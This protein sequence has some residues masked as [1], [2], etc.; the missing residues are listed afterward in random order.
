[1]LVRRYICC[2]KP[3][4]SWLGMPWMTMRKFTFKLWHLRLYLD[5][6]Q[7][8][9]THARFHFHS[10]SHWPILAIGLRGDPNGESDIWI[11]VKLS[12]CSPARAMQVT[13]V[14]LWTFM[15]SWQRLSLKMAWRRL[16]VSMKI[17]CSRRH[18]GRCPRI[19]TRKLLPVSVTVRLCQFEISYRSMIWS[20][21]LY[22]G[23]MMKLSCM[24][25]HTVWC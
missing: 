22:A 2:G 4:K 6:E 7:V 23:W 21:L 19:I 16:W 10:L 8:W 25:S 15:E 13:F 20:S 11:D 24:P 14:P 1:M 9:W 18:S 5:R 3:L 12:S 17:F